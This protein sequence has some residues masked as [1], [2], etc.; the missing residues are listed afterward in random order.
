M[1]SQYGAGA[2][3]GNTMIWNDMKTGNT[4]SFWTIGDDVARIEYKKLGK[5][6]L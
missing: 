2:R 5:S 3:D 6:G 1:L 4:I